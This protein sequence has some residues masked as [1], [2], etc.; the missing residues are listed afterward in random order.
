[1]V[2]ESLEQGGETHGPWADAGHAPRARPAMKLEDK[3]AADQAAH[4]ARD[5]K[6]ADEEAVAAVDDDDDG[7]TE[8]K[9]DD[10]RP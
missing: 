9:S 3:R 10:V 1:M 8:T 4:L 7:I 6:S 5:R 2:A